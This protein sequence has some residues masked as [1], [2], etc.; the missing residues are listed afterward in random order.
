M[1]PTEQEVK[2]NLM[3]MMENLQG[4]RNRRINADSVV[5]KANEAVNEILETSKQQYNF[6]RTS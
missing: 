1:H 5:R 2:L 3:K 4:L 6:I